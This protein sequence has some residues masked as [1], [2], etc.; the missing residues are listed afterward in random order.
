[1]DGT[2]INLMKF[3]S[4]TAHINNPVIFNFIHITGHENAK[5]KRLT[6]SKQA[7]S[8]LRPLRILKQLKSSSAKMSFQVS[9]WSRTFPKT[10]RLICE[11]KLNL[12]A[13]KIDSTKITVEVS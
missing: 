1:M 10:S 6:K 11:T 3:Q 8:I 4:S 5:E 9:Q 7:S 2:P 12:K 13:E